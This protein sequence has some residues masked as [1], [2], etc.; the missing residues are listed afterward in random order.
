MQKLDLN[1]VMVQVRE[2]REIADEMSRNRSLSNA[3]SR[4]RTSWEGQ[5]SNQFQRKCDDIAVLIN[6]E[7]TN[8]RAIANSLESNARAIADAEK[9]K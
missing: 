8:I 5:T 3:M 6:N 4:V 1:R 2:L 7:I 9:R